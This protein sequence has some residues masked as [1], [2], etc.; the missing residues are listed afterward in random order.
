MANI[1]KLLLISVLAFL[2]VPMQAQE[3]CE[4]LSENL[5]GEYRGKCKRGLAHGY[6]E[7]QGKDYYIGDFKKGYPHGNG[8]YTWSSGEKYEGEWER[9]LRDGEG[10]YYFFANGK[11]SVIYG[12]WV[13]DEYVGVYHERPYNVDF[14]DN[15]GRVTFTKVSDSRQYV[16]L[17]FMRDGGENTHISEVFLMGS[18][19]V[20]NN[21]RMFTGFENTEFPFKG[22][23]VFNA[24]NSFYAATMR[25]EVRYQIFEPG[26]WVVA[27]SY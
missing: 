26:A 24:P 20:E 8:T 12:R 22:K 21:S 10:T 18:S 5:K 1:V 13:D 17:K 4:V 3:E 19:G 2:Y 23:V 15:V 27:I 14:R 7:A 9:G 6:G 25:C 16:R 11:D